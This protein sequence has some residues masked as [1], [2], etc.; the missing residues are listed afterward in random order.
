MA[1]M[2]PSRVES[3]PTITDRH[4]PVVYRSDAHN[5]GP[6]SR[7]HLDAYEK[8]GYLLLENLFSLD[9]VDQMLKELDVVRS[10]GVNSGKPEVI[11]EPD[12]EEVRSVFAVHRDD[13]MFDRVSRDSRLTDVAQQLLDSDLYIHQSRINF[14]PG[15]TG[16]EF[17]WH[18]DFE[19]WHIEDGMPRMRAI[20]FSI[21]LDDN[22]PFNG[23]LMLVPGSHQ[24][25]V[26]CVGKTPDD[27][28]KSSLRRQEYG[29]PDRN[30][31]STLVEAGGIDMPVGR[32]G[33]VLMFECNTM[34]GS[35]SNI[36][37]FPRR[38]VF[39]VYN[40]V[41]N[42]LEAPFSGGQPRPEFIASREHQLVANT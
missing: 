23:S 8:N 20:S 17:Y 3:E 7:E 32:R 1:D 15:F 16:K 24:S 40:S 4:D 39:L 18:S 41:K 26:S 10:E 2:Y 12:S 14:K 27:H 34:H 21:L 30:S 25:Y 6:L 37:P 5:D 13:P 35:N 38:N 33:S 11:Q 36:T 9:E 42:A 31:L 29:V 22:L 19:T 28:Y